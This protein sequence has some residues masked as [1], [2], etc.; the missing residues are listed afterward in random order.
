M[1][2]GFTAGP[3]VFSVLLDKGYDVNAQ[4]EFALTPLHMAVLNGEIAPQVVRLLL[5]S[6]AELSPGLAGR[7]RPC[8]SPQPTPARRSS[9]CYW[10][11]EPMLPPGMT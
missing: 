8:I 7:S 10:S 11:G 3:Q 1:A 6:G 5:D 9:G 2:A 4:G